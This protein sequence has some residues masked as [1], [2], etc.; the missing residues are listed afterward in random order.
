MKLEKRLD[1]EPRQ[2]T[3]TRKPYKRLNKETRQI[4]FTIFN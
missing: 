2:I 1:R 4:I 3:E